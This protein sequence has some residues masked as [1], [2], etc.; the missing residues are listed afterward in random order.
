I[1]AKI[2]SASTR[3][4]HSSATS[5]GS[6]DHRSSTTSAR[7]LPPSAAM[8]PRDDRSSSYGGSIGFRIPTACCVAP[9]PVGTSKPAARRATMGDDD[10]KFAVVALSAIFFVIDPL[11]NVPM[12]LSITSAFTAEQRKR[13]AGRAALATW[14]LL[15]FFAVAGG[16]V[17]KAFGISL[18]AFKV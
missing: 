7:D 13:V 1:A 6:A 4:W 11:A 18:G 9:L 14:V 5:R 2:D 8:A 3:G 10:L 17:F 15:C 16:L 12:F